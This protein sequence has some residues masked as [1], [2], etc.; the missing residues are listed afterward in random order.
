MYKRVLSLFVFAVVF[1]GGNLVYGQLLEFANR[2][3]FDFACPD[4]V[5]E[6]FENI[7]GVSI[8]IV[9]VGF[10][11]SNSN[12]II[13]GPAGLMGSIQPGDIVPGIRIT[14]TLTDPMIE[15]LTVLGINTGDDT[16]A[17]GPT[18]FADGVVL[19]FADP[20]DCLAFDLF[21]SAL[22]GGPVMYEVTY[23][24]GNGG[25]LGVQTIENT[26]DDAAFAGVA[27]MSGPNI[28]RMAVTSEVSIVDGGVVGEVVDNI[29][30]RIGVESK[31]NEEAPESFTVFRGVALNASLADFTNSDDVSAS[32]NPGFTINSEEAPVWLIFDG[33][34]DS[35]SSFQVESTAGTPG[36]TYTAEAFNWTTNTYDV[37]G[38]QAEG[39]NSEAVVEFPLVADH[40]DAG[41]EVR[42]RVGWR[43]TG[44]TINFPWVVSVDH[45]LWSN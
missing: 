42:S 24:D 38:T 41:G 26:L 15:S 21:A 45:I 3:D 11:D 39:F 36:L 14:S 32:F 40:V 44:F 19:E 37:I 29:A 28:A 12:V 7:E 13:D 23:F 25:V 10:V 33:V 31:P 8:G 6:D 18:L 16:N 34:L 2:A 9:D 20:V 5:V 1:A 43:Q 35:A 22:A 30:F 27:V 4:T 17:I